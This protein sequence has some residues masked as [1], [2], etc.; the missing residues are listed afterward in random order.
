MNIGK[1]YQVKKFYW[2]LYPS[3]DTVP[4]AIN[5]AAA[6][7]DYMAT[8]TAACWS[9]ELKCN[10][11]FVSENN[12][13]CLLEEDGRFLKVLTTNGEIGWVD[14]PTNEE[15]AKDCIEEVNQ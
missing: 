6:S 1:F 4:A 15:W 7:N 10:V 14:Y 13:F 2:L 12:I 5:S 11:T 3:K 8:C 9:R